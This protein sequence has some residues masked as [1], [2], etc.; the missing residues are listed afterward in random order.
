[1]YI[2]VC[3]DSIES[4]LTCIYDAWEMATKVGHANVKLL[5]GPIYMN[6]L[7]D[8]LVYVE[9]DSDKASR[10]SQSIS[11]KISPDAYIS[12]YYALL[13]HEEDALDSAYRFLIIAFKMGSEALLALNSPQN[14][15]IMELRRRV[16][17]EIH[18]F[19]EFVR[20]NS[21]DNKVYISHIEPKS[22]VVE[23]VGRH[24]ADRMPS[25]YWMIID[26]NRHYAVIHPKDGENYVRLFSDEEFSRL[27]LSEDYNDSYT[28][29]WKTFFDAIAI[30]ER[31]NRRCQMNHIPLWMRKHVVE[32]G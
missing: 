30:R 28:D 12:V 26:D 27:K 5:V 6:T 1:M 13:S 14:M 15:R 8:E 21:V 4:K 10:V 17:N 31:E 9:S 18:S 11:K 16:G 24:F 25:E 19:V 20:F 32:F 7:F 23:M 22:D 29:M 2:Y 3:E